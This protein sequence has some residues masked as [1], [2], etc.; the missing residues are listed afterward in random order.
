[1]SKLV[2]GTA[3]GDYSKISSHH[4]KEAAGGYRD[5]RTNPVA[6]NVSKE[7][8]VRGR[9]GVPGSLVNNNKKPTTKTV[10]QGLEAIEKNVVIPQAGGMNMTYVMV[11][12]FVV[13]GLYYY[14]AYVNI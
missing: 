12:I 14:M 3:R 6:S 1:M 13:G 4:V 11:G 8:E 5:M 7:K 2:T 9:V 10:N